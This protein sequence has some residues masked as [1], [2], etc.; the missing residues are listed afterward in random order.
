MLNRRSFIAAGAALGAAAPALAATPGSMTAGSGLL[1]AADPKALL[2]A[3]VK[4]RGSLDGRLAFWWMKGP[5]YGVV[6][7]TVTPLFQNLVVSW[8]RFARQPDGN[9]KAT[10][11]ELSYYVDAKT[12]AL[13][14]HSWRNPITG[15]TNALEHI[16]FGPV[17]STLTPAGVSEPEKTPGVELRMKSTRGVLA[18]FNDDIWINEDVSATIVPDSGRAPYQG[19][20]ITTYHG[21][22]RQVLDPNSPSAEAT[23]HYQSATDWR[24]WMKMGDIKGVLMARASGRKVWSVGDVPTDILAA[25]RRMHP[26]IIADPVKA[27]E[28]TPPEASFRR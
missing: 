14:D 25:A 9:F 3:L 21:S 20:D 17:T 11:V 27:L 2:T 16:A 4:L 1:D 28:G 23:M 18:Q 19:N 6:G 8:H 13:L 10:I 7:T 22:L 24:S 5:R 26:Q 12:G 15:E